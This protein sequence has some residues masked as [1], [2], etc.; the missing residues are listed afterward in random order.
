[1]IWFVK[2][3]AYFLIKSKKCNYKIK[4]KKVFWGEKHWILME[5]SK[6]WDTTT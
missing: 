4:G 3:A 6:R 5:K 1:M 2:N